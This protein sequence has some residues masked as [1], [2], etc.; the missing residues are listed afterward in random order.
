M[1][2]DWSSKAHDWVRNE[3]IIDAAFAPFTNALLAAADIG[4]ARKVLDVGCGTGSILQAVDAHGA[5]AVGVDVS[6]PMVEAARSRVP[7]ATIVCA[8]AQSADLTP[9][10]GDEG[11]DRVVSR[12]GVMFFAD[13]PVAFANLRAVAA[14]GARLTF[15]CWR[16]GETNL[17]THGL[18]RI[19]SLLDQPPG[20]PAVG[21]PGP[22]G[23]ADPTYLREVLESAGWSDVTISPLDGTCDFGIDGSDGV[24][25]RLA[26]A[27]A[28]TTGRQARAELEPRLGP[29]R[30]AEVL[31]ETRDD[32]RSS[33]DGGVVRF[34]SRT[35]LVT[36]AAL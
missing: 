12:F 23:L 36:A 11:F 3:P 13:P 4:S 18:E 24:E 30:W 5:I 27:L 15:V 10:A 25:E 31:D 6:E 28:G 33:L 8:D 21:V 35:W 22:M 19:F 9:V 2:D 16:E 29:V 7:N 26:M 1:S 34:T 14:Q 20:P 17:F 32:L